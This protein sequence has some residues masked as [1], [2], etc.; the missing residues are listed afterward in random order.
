MVIRLPK[1]PRGKKNQRK[2]TV[3]AHAGICY[4]VSMFYSF[5]HYQE[6]F[7]IFFFMASVAATAS[8]Q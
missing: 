1:I 6:H 2:S 4:A 3:T 7:V 8:F 5:R